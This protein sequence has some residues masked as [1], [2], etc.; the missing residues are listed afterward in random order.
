MVSFRINHE[1]RDLISTAKFTTSFVGCSPL[2]DRQCIKTSD[3]QTCLKQV[4][5]RR[6]DC[7][8]NLEKLKE[9]MSLLQKPE[10]VS[11]VAVKKT[12]QEEFLE[13]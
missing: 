13:K 3:I 6:N 10:K 8:K 4:L 9:K 11:D 5:S 12:Q 1:L 2:C 7:C